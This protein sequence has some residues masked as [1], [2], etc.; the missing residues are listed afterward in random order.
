MVIKNRVRETALVGRAL[1]V[2][3]QIFLLKE[4]INAIEVSDNAIFRH[5]VFLGQVQAASGAVLD[6]AANFFNLHASNAVGVSLNV[7]VNR[8]IDRNTVSIERVFA[9][10]LFHV[11]TD[12]FV[13]VQARFVGNFLLGEFDRGLDIFVVF[14][15]VNVASIAHGIKHSIATFKRCFGVTVRAVSFRALQHTGEHSEFRNRKA[16]EWATE[17]ELTCSLETV[18]TT[19]QVHFVHV[20]FKDFF[21]RVSLF[22]AD[23]RH[24]FLDLTRNRTFRSQE[25]EFS[26]LLR[27]GRGTAE[28]FA[29]HGAFHNGRRNRPHVHAPV[30]IEGAVFG[31]HHSVNG[32]FGN[33]VKARPFAAFHKIFVSNLSVHVINVRDKSRIDLFQLRKRRKLRREMIVDRDYS[34]KCRQ[35]GNRKN[36]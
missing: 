17:I 13:E 9:I 18:V 20:E 16:I 32:I 29:R 6:A 10:L 35:N 5:V 2:V 27:Q 24:H 30:A 28:L 12:F 34:D 15:V 21:F 4:S 1:Q 25:Q 23:C 7:R 36:D 22:D 3:G 11:L 26:Q 14:V 8:R 19:S 33:R 31:S